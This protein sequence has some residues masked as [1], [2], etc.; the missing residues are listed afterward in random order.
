MQKNLKS[1]S[2]INTVNSKVVLKIM[3]SKDMK[4][5]LYLCVLQ[6]VMYIVRKVTPSMSL[7]LDIRAFSW[8]LNL[9]SCLIVTV[10][11]GQS[12]EPTLSLT[13]L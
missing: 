2:I 3:I 11:Q 8:L 12:S 5:V 1:R 6:R 7:T 4:L 13:L 10:V 9:C